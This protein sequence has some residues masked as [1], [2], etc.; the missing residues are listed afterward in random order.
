MMLSESVCISLI[1]NHLKFYMITSLDMNLLRALSPSTIQSNTSFCRTNELAKCVAFF[2]CVCLLQ[3]STHFG[4]F[5]FYIRVAKSYY[6]ISEVK[7]N[8]RKKL[9]QKKG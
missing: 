2:F 3:G 1:C 6:K 7:P 8:G 4:Q 5:M 9:S